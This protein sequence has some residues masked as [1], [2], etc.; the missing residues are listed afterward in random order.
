MA[1]LRITLVR[2]TLDR[3]RDQQ[4]TARSL[5][6]TRIRKTVVHQDTPQIR[7]MVTAIRHLVKVEQIPES[8]GDGVVG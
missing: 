5:G 4:H 8:P 7:G 1:Q 3:Q 6:L 2:S